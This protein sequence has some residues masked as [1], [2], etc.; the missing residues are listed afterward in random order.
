MCS[1]WAGD[2]YP[3]TIWLSLLVVASI[4]ALLTVGKQLWEVE[5][6]C[7]TQRMLLLPQTGNTIRRSDLR[8]YPG[9]GD[10]DF[11]LDIRLAV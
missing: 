3:N 5:C 4:I 7:M 8:W 1:F 11:K 6:A 9:I 10:G 2:T